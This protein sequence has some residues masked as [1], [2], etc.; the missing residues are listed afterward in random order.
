MNDKLNEQG[1]TGCCP[2]FNP[3]LWEDKEVSLKDKLFIK[4][5]VRSFIHIPLNM[6]K[7]MVKN[8]DRIEAADFEGITAILTASPYYNKPTQ[9]GIFN[10]YMAIAG[11]SVNKQNDRNMISSKIQG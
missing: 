1:E 8:M 3:E 11:T 5:H 2:R 4:D 6:G 9:K 7:V 10:H